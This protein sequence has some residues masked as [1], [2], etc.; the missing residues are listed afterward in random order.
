MDVDENGTILVIDDDTGPRESL[1]F[2]LRK[3]HEVL[4]ASQVD[5]GLAYLREEKVDVVLLDLRMPGI[6]GIEGLKMIRQIDSHVAVIILTGYASLETATKAIRLGANE[7]LTKPFDIYSMKETIER[8]LLETRMRRE[9]ADAFTQLGELNL[10][11]QRE[12][13]QQNKILELGQNADELFHDLAN[14]LTIAYGYTQMLL[15]QLAQEPKNLT[16]QQLVQYLRRMNAGLQRCKELTDLWGSRSK[17]EQVEDINLAT[18]L[19]DVVEAAEVG[20]RSVTLNIADAVQ[21]QI[22]QADPLQVRRIFENI[23]INALQA[24]DQELGQVVVEVDVDH[25]HVV[26]S[27]RDNGTGIAEEIRDQIFKPYVSTKGDQ[28]TGLGLYIVKKLVRQYKGR[29]SVESEKG[30]GTVFTVMLPISEGR[31]SS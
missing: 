31:H 4:C 11:L 5:A 30:K 27:V 18:L 15:A 25:P 26:T 16:Q 6:N 10:E 9:Q 13:T 7:Y 8:H 21:E 20:A 28:G 2:L 12:L 19:R 1:R 23:L 17:E 29:V 22:V 14:P 24:V 3:R